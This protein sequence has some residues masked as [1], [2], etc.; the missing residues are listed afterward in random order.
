MK[1]ISKTWLV[2]I[3]IILMIVGYYIA[4]SVFKNPT[5][6]YVL[7]KVSKGDVVQEVSETG[8]VKATENISLGFKSIGKIAKINIAVGDKVKKGDVLA[9]LDSSQ[10]SAQ[11]QSARAALNY[12]AN[13]YDSGVASAKD[14]LQSAYKSALNVLSDA[15]TEI[16]NA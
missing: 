2:I 15:Y 9:E 14:N 3:V 13:Q 16:Y 11:L 8:S 5:D 10:I 4:K 12:T 6:A 1:K 7:E